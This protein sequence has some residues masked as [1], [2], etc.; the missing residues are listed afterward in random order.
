MLVR[1][2][3]AIFAASALSS[4]SHLAIASEEPVIT[5]AP[6]LTR[7]RDATKVE[8]SVDRQSDAQ[9][10]EL[11]ARTPGEDLG[12][13]ALE[14]RDFVAS[15][16][17]NYV[18]CNDGTCCF[19]GEVCYKSG[20]QSKCRYA[21]FGD[22][23]IDINSILDS[24]SA[25]MSDFPAEFGD[26]LTDIPTNSASLSAYIASLTSAEFAAFHTNGPSATK[27]A[28]SNSRG[29]NSAAFQTDGS[30]N[31]PKKGLSGGAIG[32]IVAGVILILAAIAGALTFV[33]FRRNRKK[34]Q[35]AAAIPPQPQQPPQ[36]DQPGYPSQSTAPPTPRTVYSQVAPPYPGIE[37]G[38]YAQQQQNPG[39]DY[40]KPP[41]P[42]AQE[43][44]GDFKQQGTYVPPPV[45]QQE[46][47]VPAP[48]TVQGQQQ[49]WHQHPPPQNPHE[50][51]ISP[52]P[53][54]QQWQPPQSPLSPQPPQPPYPIPAGSGHN[55]PVYEM[56]TGL[57]R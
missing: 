6:S 12:A 19:S 27:S 5:P 34:Q 43:T 4:F 15:C 36:M 10:R 54:Q 31:A 25:M 52:M 38:A 35:A 30:S 47:P 39:T 21:G 1:S 23:S 33:L 32:G 46:L 37:N 18:D 53:V 41:I 45:G 57:A 24:L 7:D 22:Y 29:S 28:N 2:F 56:D 3:V 48:G 13:Q 40:Y 14:V 16:G 55:N 44:L 11:K 26:Y 51:T 50:L 42:G 8:V 17:Y 49:Q 9:N 20:T